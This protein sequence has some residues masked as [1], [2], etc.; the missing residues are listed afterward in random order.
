MARPPPPADVPNTDQ[1]AQ[2]DA[3]L[4]LKK[5]LDQR[6]EALVDQ[7]NEYIKQAD[8]YNSTYQGV[9]SDSPLYAP[10]QAAYAN[11]M[12][13]YN[14]YMGAAGAFKSDVAS[15]RLAT[16]PPPP[17]APFDPRSLITKDDYNDALKAEQLLLTRQ[18]GLQDQI[19]KL[20]AWQQGLQTD[21]DEFAKIKQEA[22]IDYLNDVLL[23]LPV[24]DILGQFVKGSYLTYQQAS[25]L[26]A[27]F[28]ALKGLVNIEGGID[29]ESSQEKLDKITDAQSNIRAALLDQA[30]ATLKNSSSPDD[31]KS[32]EYLENVG[33]T[34][35]VA[36]DMIKFSQ[37]GDHSL[38]AWATFGVKM[39]ADIVPVAKYGTSI[40]A[41]GEKVA[42]QYVVQEPLNSLN[43]AMSSNFNAQRYLQTKLDPINASVS[44]LQE[45]VDNYRAVHPQS[46][47]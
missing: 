16:S 33:K 2:D 14:A 13:L 11:L 6:H 36:I 8:A 7:F 15:L 35:D 20:K 24:G 41:V 23:K 4:A 5:D 10:G 45:K 39:T 26:Q 1:I 43:E 19:A 40:Y 42:V 31:Q 37:Q 17:A 44:A 27:G 38:T 18:Q 29:A 21:T 32:F 12:G 28:D 9:E 22:Q 25:A 47:W 3:N 34:F 46:D 30:M